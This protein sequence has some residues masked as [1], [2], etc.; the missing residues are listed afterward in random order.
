MTWSWFF[1]LSRHAFEFQPSPSTLLQYHHQEGAVRI[2][3]TRVQCVAKSTRGRERS[4]ITSD[5][6]IKLNVSSSPLTHTLI[7][8]TS[9]CF[10]LKELPP[11]VA[12]SAVWLSLTIAIT[13]EVTFLR[14]KVDRAATSSRPSG[15]HGK[16]KGS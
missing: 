3:L 12:F 10:L 1:L 14:Q 15:P 16:E 11:L 6:S 13:A 9:H 4:T 7:G 2:C 5:V 8:A